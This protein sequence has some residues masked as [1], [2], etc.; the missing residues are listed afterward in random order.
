MSDLSIPTNTG[1]MGVGFNL[2]GQV[3]DGTGTTCAELTP[4]LT[5]TITS[6]TGVDNAFAA[7]VPQLE[8]TLLMGRMIGAL[9]GEQITAGSFILLMEVSDIN[10]YTSDSA[11]QVRLILGRVP[12]CVSGMPATCM[13]MVS[14]ATIA[15][16]QTFEQVMVLGSAVSGSIAG[17]RMTVSTPSL[18][19]ALS[20]GSSSLTLTIRN[21]SIGAAISASALTNGEI[22]G[23]LQIEELAVSAE[24]LMAGA[25]ATVRTVVGAVADLEPTTADPA[26][27]AS[28]GIGATFNAVDAEL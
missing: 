14:G 8:R 24:S 28:I 11:V 16:G 26:T 7:L 23:S 17:G 12:G 27:C 1:T 3:D 18:P 13:P 5:S 22:G 15:P 2:D 10:S 4:D 21:A 20:I 19:L 6:A 25:G 9:V